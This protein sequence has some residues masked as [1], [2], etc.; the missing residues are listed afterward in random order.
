MSANWIYFAA[1]VIGVAMA[2]VVGVCVG[3]N[4]VGDCVVTLLPVLAVTIPEMFPTLSITKTNVA[5]CALVTL[6]LAWAGYLVVARWRKSR[7]KG[8]V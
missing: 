2:M 3:R 1:I 7:R 4:R 8:M 6:L 5:V